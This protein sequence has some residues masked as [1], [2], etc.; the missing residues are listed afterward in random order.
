MLIKNLSR[1][2]K[3]CL[4]FIITDLSA[5]PNCNPKIF[6]FES[7]EE[8]IYDIEYLM[9][10]TWVTAGKVRFKVEDSIVQN[11]NCLYIEGKGRTLKNYDWF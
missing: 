3:I 7:G 6:P 4:L 8:I 2:F 10:K 11:I 9:G 5:Q 1:I